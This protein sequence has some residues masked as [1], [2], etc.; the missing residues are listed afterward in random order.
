MEVLQRDQHYIRFI[1][2]F[3]QS[4]DNSIGKMDSFTFPV[5]FRDRVRDLAPSRVQNGLSPFQRGRIAER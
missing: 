3:T 4:R 2:R 5:L 1:S